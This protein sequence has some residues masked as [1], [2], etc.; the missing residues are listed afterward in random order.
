MLAERRTLSPGVYHN[1]VDG[2]TS[3][4]HQFGLAATRAAMEPAQ[5]A[6]DCSR[7]AVLNKGLR[8]DPRLLGHEYIKRASE[9][10]T[11]I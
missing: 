10:A 1:V 8:L 4:T 5:H 7:L 6:C 11:L 9:E 3:T 2:T